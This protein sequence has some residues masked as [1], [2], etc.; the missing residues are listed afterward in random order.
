MPRHEIL[1]HTRI[2]Q[3]VR[4]HFQMI[5]HCHGTLDRLNSV[6]FPL[7]QELAS[8][9]PGGRHR[10]TAY[11]R[12]FARGVFDAFWHTLMQE[13]VEFVYKLRRDV[14]QINAKRDELFSTHK[15]SVHR[16]TEEFYEAE[17]GI[18]LSDAYHS[19]VWKGTDKPIGAWAMP[20]PRRDHYPGVKLYAA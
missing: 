11:T 3:Q 15:Q 17:L 9:T 5:E 13:K 12:G 7:W 18:L 19:H 16:L 14:P 1:S 4:S 20:R 10:Y 2:E 8:K 6:M